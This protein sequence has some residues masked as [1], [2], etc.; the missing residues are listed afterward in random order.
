MS[1]SPC[2]GGAAGWLVLCACVV[3]AGGAVGAVAVAVGEAA[4]DGWVGGVVVEVEVPGLVAV[5][6]LSA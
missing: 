1:V 4:V 5:H 3:A 2:A 6:G